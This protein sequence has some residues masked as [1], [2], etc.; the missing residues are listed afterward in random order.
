MTNEEMDKT[1]EFMKEH[2]AH[3]TAKVNETS[4]LQAQYKARQAETEVRLSRVEESFALL[5]QL[6]ERHTSEGRNGKP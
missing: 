1:I 6:I 2:L 5:V 4:T 3:I